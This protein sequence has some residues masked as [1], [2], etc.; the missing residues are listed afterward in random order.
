MAEPMTH[1][2]TVRSRCQ[3]REG[4]TFTQDVLMLVGLIVWRPVEVR[5]QPVHVVQAVCLSSDEEAGL[6]PPQ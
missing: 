3:R 5:E 4:D 2:T 6:R 1:V